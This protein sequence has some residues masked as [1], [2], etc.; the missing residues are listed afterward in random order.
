MYMY[1]CP[2][3]PHVTVLAVNIFPKRKC[4]GNIGLVLSNGDLIGGTGNLLDDNFSYWGR[5][6]ADITLSISVYN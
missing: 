6:H 4:D 1:G 3:F 2:L 5:Y